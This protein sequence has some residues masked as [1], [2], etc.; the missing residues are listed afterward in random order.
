MATAR[1]RTQQIGR[2]AHRRASEE[3]STWNVAQPATIDVGKRGEFQPASTGG[4][5]SWKGARRVK[6]GDSS[7]FLHYS[8]HVHCTAHVHSESSVSILRS[9][10]YVTQQRGSSNESETVRASRAG[11]RP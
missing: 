3:E 10:L 5:R 2:M 11:R 9:G 8:A 6:R 7:S 4:R 1:R